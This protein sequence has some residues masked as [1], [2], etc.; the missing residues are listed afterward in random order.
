MI[1]CDRAM[2]VPC[3]AQ[4]MMPSGAGK[5]VSL[6]EYSRRM[7]DRCIYLQA[8][9][10]FAGKEGILYELAR[11][12]GFKPYKRERSQTVY[13]YIRGRL[14][15]YY[16]GGK[17]VPMMLI[18]DEATTLRPAAINLLRNLHDDPACRMALVLADTWRM[19]RELSGRNQIAG[20][21][22]QLRRRFGAV[23]RMRPDQEIS[24]ADSRLVADSILA[25]LGHGHKLHPDSYK[26]LHRLTQLPGKFGNIASRLH[27]VH[28]V[29]ESQ[30]VSPAY[31]VAQ[32]DYV[33]ELVGMEMNIAHSAPPFAAL[34]CRQA[35]PAGAKAAGAS[36]QRV[37]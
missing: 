26:F 12:L 19:D 18:V 7:G 32:L 10:A 11:R 29:A 8:G 37:A 35:T 22:E 13:E 21:Y 15:D 9:E 25:S 28:D 14:A 36:G 31:T 6:T 1:A 4:I 30:R 34:P 16:E 24:A 5:T 17:G 33:A 27:A 23:Y 3:I 20:G 2:G